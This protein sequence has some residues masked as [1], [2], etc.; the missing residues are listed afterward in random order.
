[1]LAAF[2]N[3]TGGLGGI[4]QRIREDKEVLRAGKR[5]EMLQS[6]E[7]VGV[8][9]NGRTRVMQTGASKDQQSEERVREHP[10]YSQYQTEPAVSTRAGGCDAVRLKRRCARWML[11]SLW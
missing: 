7:I 4:S 1:M 3:C 6:D 8:R 11:A 5:E 10:W 2:V 9:V